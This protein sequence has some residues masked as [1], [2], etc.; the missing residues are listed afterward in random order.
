MVVLQKYIQIEDS[1]NDNFMVRYINCTPDELTLQI[2]NN[3]DLL[4]TVEQ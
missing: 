2:T 4:G 3:K 1:E